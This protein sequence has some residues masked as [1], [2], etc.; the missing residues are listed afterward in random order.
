[1]EVIAVTNPVQYA[2]V[3]QPAQGIQIIVIDELADKIFF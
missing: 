1:M 3:T 2:P